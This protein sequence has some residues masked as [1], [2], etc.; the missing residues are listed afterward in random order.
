MKSSFFDYIF[1]G[2]LVFCKAIK[3]GDR[4]LF[5][6]ELSRETEKWGRVLFQK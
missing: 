1:L 4:K 6:L 2:S 5:F 3:F